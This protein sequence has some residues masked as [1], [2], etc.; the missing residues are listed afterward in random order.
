MKFIRTS[1]MALALLLPAA[2]LQAATIDQFAPVAGGESAFF[3]VTVIAAPPTLTA[4]GGDWTAS[5]SE[6]VQSDVVRGF[7]SPFELTL[8]SVVEEFGPSSLYHGVFEVTGGT[9]ASLWGDYAIVQ[10]VSGGESFGFGTQATM[11]VQEAA[12]I[13][14][15]AGAVL[16]LTGLALLGIARARKPAL[17]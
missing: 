7:Q 6:T 4:F 8:A 10:I 13:P 15:P 12:V 16:L 11:S 14:L 3:P 9:A 2:V 1:A 17:A 5:L